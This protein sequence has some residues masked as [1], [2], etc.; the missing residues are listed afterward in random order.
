MAE[1]RKKIL[2]LGGGFGGVYAAERLCELSCKDM[3]IDVTLVNKTNYFLF[4]PLL[5][6][7]ATGSLSRNSILL[8]IREMMKRNNFNFV[9][10]EIESIDLK[11]K[12]AN[13]WTSDE[14]IQ[15]NYDYIIT[16]LGSTTNYFATP[17]ADENAFTLKSVDDA[18]RLMHHLVEMFEI[19]Q[20]KSEEEK[21]RMLRFVV[22]G[23]GPT[24]IETAAEMH[25]L[26]KE[27]MAGIYR[28]NKKDI[29]IIVVNSSDQLL[30]G[31][32]KKL[33]KVASKRLEKLGIKVMRNSRVT[34]V[35]PNGVEINGK[36]F[37][38]T[39][40]KLWTA[41]VMP[42]VVDI[43]PEIERDKMKIVVDNKLRIKDHPFAF[44]IGDNA[45]VKDTWYPATA[46]VALQQAKHSAES[47]YNMINGKEAKEFKY[48]HRGSLMSLGPHYAAAHIGDNVYS[49]KWVWF[50][51]RTVY[52][53]KMM[54]TRNKV[55]IAM[56]WFSELLFKRNTSQV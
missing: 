33:D 44:A 38:E 52:L 12:T 35:E 18:E 28:K 54:G 55:R 42:N 30:K 43:H 19:A 25:D 45:V 10:G 5:H 47:I 41:G 3:G 11:A 27:N 24:G 37:I 2:I 48:N 49:G 46:Q 6:E 50:F 23:G 21:K 39:Y 51:W 9:K 34:K 14:R 17:G 22:I 1:K 36:D 40:T 7:V 15:L 8:P 29:E 13:V 20:V 53:S 4:T 56:D 16:A 32:S 26:I 31:L